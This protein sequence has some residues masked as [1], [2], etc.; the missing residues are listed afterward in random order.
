LADIAMFLTGSC[1]CEIKAMNPGFDIFLPIDWYEGITE[2]FVLDA[3]L[4]PLT[5]ASVEPQS[6][7]EPVPAPEPD[8]GAAVKVSVDTRTVPRT[9]TILRI[10]L[11]VGGLAVLILAATTWVWLRRT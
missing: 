5:G 1:S 4:P 9:E 3:T 11:V 2:E 7:A 10:V 8:P 6:V